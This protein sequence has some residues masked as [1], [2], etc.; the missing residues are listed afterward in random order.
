[1]T[2]LLE[3]IVAIIAPHTCIVCSFNDNIICTSCIYNMPSQT[4]A[5]ILCGVRSP[6]WQV[7]HQCRPATVLQKVWFGAMYEGPVE[8]AIQQFK[9]G[10]AYAAHKPLSEIMDAALP[11]LPQDWLI[12]PVPTAPAHIRQ[13]GYDQTLLLARRLAKK[14]QLQ[15][16]RV[17]RRLHNARQVGASRAERQRQA[18]QA[19]SVVEP[20]SLR[21]RSILLV[22]DVC[23]TGA[24]LNAAAKLLKQAGAQ[25]INAVVAARRSFNHVPS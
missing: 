11:Y 20:A 22:D 7:C 10:R 13:R 18:A 9:F 17:L 6:D 21:G 8:Q 19:F 23:T 3:N 16:S 15:L 24:T 2:S 5:C 12:V 25:Q 14:R 1:M 4:S